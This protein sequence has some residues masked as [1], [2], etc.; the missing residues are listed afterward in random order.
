MNPIMA[1]YDYIDVSGS[2]SGAL[3]LTGAGE[4]GVTGIDDTDHPAS[5]VLV[6]YQGV[7]WR[8]RRLPGLRVGAD[9]RNG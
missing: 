6:Y 3:S 9:L 2:G 5:F 1:T 4:P 8:W 7:S